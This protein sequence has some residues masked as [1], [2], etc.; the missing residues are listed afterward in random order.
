MAI[1]SASDNTSVPAR[2]QGR[3][4]TGGAIATIIGVALLIIVIIQN[5]QRVAVDF[6]F[7]T[8]TWPIWAFAVVMAMIGAL[9]WF[10]LGVIRR[11]RR[12]QERR[13]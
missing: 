9:T 2:R 13:S 8:F 3:Q 10:G 5:T 1:K 4:L 11:H 6:L 7:W 12:R